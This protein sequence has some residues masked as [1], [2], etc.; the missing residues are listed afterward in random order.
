MTTAGDLV[1]SVSAILHGYGITQ[2]RVTALTNSIGP[3]DLTFVVDA[4]FGPASG[5]QPGMVE[6]DTEL[7]HVI[8]IDQASNT[9]TVANGFG[10]GHL[11]TTA[12]A[13]TAG[14]KVTSRPK[15][16]RSQIM[17][18]LNNVVGAVFPQ[19]YGTK[20]FTGTVTYPSNS[21]ALTGGPIR[22]LA[23]QWQDF[24]GNWQD[25]RGYQFDSFD[26]SLRI[27][28]AGPIGRPL[29]VLYNVQPGLFSTEADDYAGITGLPLSAQDV[30]TKGAAA[31]LILGVDISRAQS[32]SIEQSDRS[33]VVPPN[34]GA[35]AGKFLLAEYSQRLQNEAQTLRQQYTPRMVRKWA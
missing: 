18:E 9:C 33:R 1:S 4:T 19:L 8:N 21:Y 20:T 7:L 28:G 26:H 35:S 10:R 32:T 34:A 11:N 14:A 25:V 12:V 27:L 30:L 31:A 22:V 2:D 3:S 15:F 6:I 24:L 5:V 17:T 16:P 23:C 29:R 13:H